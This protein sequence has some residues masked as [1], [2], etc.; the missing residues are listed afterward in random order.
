MP[1]PLAGGKSLAAALA[2]DHPLPAAV[3]GLSAHPL[4]SF[5]APG[6]PGQVDQGF[7]A[8]LGGLESEPAKQR[9]V[10]VRNVVK[11][12]HQLARS[13]AYSS[14]SASSCGL[15]AVVGQQSA[16]NVEI[17]ARRART[18]RRLVRRATK[19]ARAR[20]RSPDTSRTSGR[21]GRRVVRL[22]RPSSGKDKRR[23]A[24][25]SASAIDIAGKLFDARSGAHAERRARAGLMRVGSFLGDAG[26]QGRDP[27]RCS[28]E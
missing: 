24:R 26:R 7:F 17:A 11:R 21:S 23:A 15:S 6:L 16:A 25:S 14:N 19:T 4:E 8:P 27:S 22:D 3:V 20:V 9:Q 12:Q 5:A 1:L 18:P 28:S 13:T 2:E 10:F